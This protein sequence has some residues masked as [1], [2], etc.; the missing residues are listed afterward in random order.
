MKS[1]G[2]Y[3]GIDKLA[4]VE[5]SGKKALNN[6]QVGRN[7]ISGNMDEARQKITDEVKLV[8]YFKEEIRRN[9]ID[10]KEAAIAISGKDMIIR[11]FDM[12]VMPRNELDAAVSFEARKYVPFRLDELVYDFQVQLDK[13]NN[14]NRVLF[15]GIKRDIF[16]KYISIAQQLDTKVV[17]AEYSAFSVLR[18]LKLA[19]VKNQGVTAILTA[20]PQEGDELNFLVLESDFP[21]FNRDIMYGGG[22]AVATG[23]A[24]EQN[25]GLILEKLK[26]EIRISLDYYN[27][28]F[29][30]KKIEKII[31]LMGQAE[32]VELEHFLQE[33]GIATQYVDILKLI[34]RPTVF[35]ISLIKGFSVS[36]FKTVKSGLALDLLKARERIDASKKP[37][38]APTLSLKDIKPDARI[39]ILGLFV[40]AAAFFYGIFRANPVKKDI[41][42][43]VS[44]RPAVATVSAGSTNE[45]L[46]A[47]NSIFKKKVT[48]LDNLIKEQMSLTMQ[49]DSIPRIVPDG[50]W[51]GGFS[52]RKDKEDLELII[53][54]F[55]ELND[56][57][58]ELAVINTFLN[59]LKESPNIAKNFKEI[60]I[61]SLKRSE[62]ASIYGS[63]DELQKRIIFTEF[64]ITCKGAV[65]KGIPESGEVYEG[66][67]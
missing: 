43:I 31:L 30:S 27:R 21:L 33:F 46:Q 8:A 57:K 45:D 51:L 65:R 11:T 23:A 28:N 18:A 2:I 16:D 25:P 20:D 40:C 3:F 7:I 44:L 5:S 26:T 32:V 48:A 36:L 13:L 15:A 54:G 35:S 60:D 10:A 49:L 12:P 1:L 67:E 4:L 17:G 9:K 61:T 29:P 53:N 63:E 42:Q 58:E 19:G 41:E 39:I 66:G 38:F 52:F 14:R 34:N 55:S 62:G 56:S 22:P 47:E 6:V 24:A 59:R 37:V 50:I 64:Q